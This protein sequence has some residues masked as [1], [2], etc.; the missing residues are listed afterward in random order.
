M[1]LKDRVLQRKPL[2]EPVTIAGESF[3]IVGKTRRERGAIFARCRKKDGSV[4]GDRLEAMLLAECVHD[5]ETG[6]PI[7]SVAEYRAW[8]DVDSGL[9]GPLLAEVMRVLG[10]DKQDIGPKGSDSTES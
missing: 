7:F 8:D 5:P 2:S 1:S 6:Q 9:T 10:M 4:D 3:L